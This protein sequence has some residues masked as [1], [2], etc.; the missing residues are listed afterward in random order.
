MAKDSK[1]GTAKTD[2][3]PPAAAT[4]PAARHASSVAQGERDARD[5]GLLQP[6]RDVRDL[7]DDLAAGEWVKKADLVG[8]GPF[9]MVGASQRQNN[10][11][12]KITDQYVFEIQFLGDAENDI[13]GTRA[14]VSMEANMVR[15]KYYRAVKK[16]GGVGPLVLTVQDTDAPGMS[17]AFVFAHP[18]DVGAGATAESTVAAAAEAEDDAHGGGKLPF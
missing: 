2:A 13:R 3:P 17:A 1:R 5:A 11:K 15:E 9:N 10:F 12:N 8:M 14:L 6:V 7:A 16:Y 18:D 4:A